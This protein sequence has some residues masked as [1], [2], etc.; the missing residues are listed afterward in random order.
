VTRALLAIPEFSSFVLLAFFA[1]NSQAADFRQPTELAWFNDQASQ[2]EALSQK[3]VE[4]VA[5]SE[6][7]RLRL[8]R[9][10]F[11]SPRLLGGQ[12]G[13]MGLS[14][15]SCHPSGRRNDRFFIDQISDQPGHADISHHF[16]SS[17]GGD[18]KFNPKPIPDLAD[19]DN[20]VFKN[21]NDSKFDDLL[22]RLI[23]IEFDGQPASALVFESLKEYLAHND[24]SN[25]ETPSLAIA[26]NA[27]TDWI[28]I[29][30]GLLALN[31]SIEVNDIETLKLVVASMRSTLETFYRFY[32]IKPVDSL[33]RSLFDI[34]D[35][36]QKFS[37]LERSQYADAQSELINELHALKD[38]LRLHQSDSF[39]NYNAAL[40]HLSRVGRQ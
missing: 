26:R 17:Q 12:A 38:Q 8:G 28:M 24:L 15:A 3:P 30:D 5:L 25:C 9:L 39:Y 11:N 32:S 19:V 34:S 7:P 22:T 29:D 13:R 14:C 27:K 10:V 40:E 1:L 18:E 33:D 31:Y 16:L 2:L 36:L 23:E 37:K 35:K 4:C 20:L 6:D 21:R